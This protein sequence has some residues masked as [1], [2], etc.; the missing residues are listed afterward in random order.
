[1]A[2]EPVLRAKS[3]RQCMASCAANPGPIVLVAVDAG[4]HL[5]RQDKLDVLLCSYIPVASRT[6]YV[7][8]HVPFMA[9][10]NEIGELVS[11]C[12]RS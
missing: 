12:A 9:E 4:L 3:L 5:H 7:L 1:M 6:G 10:E 11:R 2:H 8:D